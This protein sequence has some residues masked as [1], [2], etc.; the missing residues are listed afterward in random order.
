MTIEAVS[1]KLLKVDKFDYKSIRLKHIAQ[2]IRIDSTDFQLQLLIN[3]TLGQVDSE[4]E[5][6]NNL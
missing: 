4:T 2:I 5:E 3:Y 6:A 1:I